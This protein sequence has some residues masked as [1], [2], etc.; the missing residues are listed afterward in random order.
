MNGK[1]GRRRIFPRFGVKEDVDREL[2]T[3]MELCAEELVEEGWEWE[4]AR[5]EAQRRFGNE[6]RISRQCR[7]DD[8]PRVGKAHQG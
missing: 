3:H 8:S 2:Q 4:E 6:R 1:G 7:G 5:R